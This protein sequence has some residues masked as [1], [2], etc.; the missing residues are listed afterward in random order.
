MPTLFVENTIGASL[1]DIERRLAP[2]GARLVKTYPNVGALLHTQL[3]LFDAP[4]GAPL[5]PMVVALR[6]MATRLEAAG[7][8][9]T[10]YSITLQPLDGPTG[11]EY[12]SL[13][14]IMDMTGA[15]RA[16]ARSSR[17]GAGVVLLVV[18]SGVDRSVVPLERQAGGWTDDPDGDPWVDRA[19]HGSMV[20]RLASACCPNSK[21]FSV[22]ARA[23]PEGELLIES[24]LSAVDDLLP[25]MQ[26][27]RDLLWVMN[28]SWGYVGCE[29]DP[30]WCEVVA[31]RLIRA[32]DQGNQV[33]ISFAAGNNNLVC[34]GAP[35]IVAINSTEG[36]FTTAALDQQGRPQD[37]S[38]RGPGQCNALCPFV[39]VPTWGVLPWGAG[40]RD[41]G[42]E[43]GRTSAAAAMLS[44]A[45]SLLRGEYPQANNTDLRVALAASAVK[46]PG[47]IPFHDPATGFGMLQ[48][49]GAL[50]ALPAARASPLY[51]FLAGRGFLRPPVFPGLPFPGAG[52]TMV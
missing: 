48:V 21:I 26:A 41:F 24:V 46:T 40:W 14:A 42:P 27:N 3:A 33:S 22:K 32:L 12:S 13:P 4:P 9:I 20:A 1:A 37:Y 45:L 7:P 30:R 2:F 35:S 47:S 19:G 17:G 29:M 5:A 49:D 44:C 51:P 52:T 43:G 36:G 18:D 39:A 15:D 34:G 16:L 38:S 11:P 10:N 8:A 31:S 25:L 23:S 6:G 50:S 28:N